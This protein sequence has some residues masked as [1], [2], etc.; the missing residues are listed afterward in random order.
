MLLF[1][2]LFKQINRLPI[3]TYNNQLFKIHRLNDSDYELSFHKLNYIKVKNID[4]LNDTKINGIPAIIIYGN[5]GS[6]WY[7]GLEKELKSIFRKNLIYAI[8]NVNKY[9]KENSIQNGL[10]MPFYSVNKI[11]LIK[12]YNLLFLRFFIRKKI[13]TLNEKEYFKIP[14]IPIEYIPCMNVFKSEYKNYNKYRDEFESYSSERLVDKFNIELNV[15][16]NQDREVRLVAYH[17]VFSK[18]FNKSP[19][20]RMDNNVIILNNKIIYIK[21]LDTVLCYPHIN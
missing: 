4:E 21:E 14:D 3:E 13:M 20:T 10:G 1:N 17:D 5:I 6:L 11:T 18:R 15:A 19:I 9:N 7:M 16:H 2:F 12:N 8:I